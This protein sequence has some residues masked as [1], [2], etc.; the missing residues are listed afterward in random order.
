MTMILKDNF[1]ARTRCGFNL[2]LYSFGIWDDHSITTIFI[3]DLTLGVCFY[4][5]SELVLTWNKDPI[6]A[7]KLHILAQR[8]VLSFIAFN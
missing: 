8:D 1:Y 5:F 2:G 7:D 3:F 4:N 6:V